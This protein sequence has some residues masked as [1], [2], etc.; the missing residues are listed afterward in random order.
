MYHMKA[1]SRATDM[2]FTD[3]E[4]WSLKS[5][6]AFDTF[7]E[8][9]SVKHNVSSEKNNE[10]GGVRRYRTF[11]VCF[12]ESEKGHVLYMNFN[13]TV[14]GCVCFSLDDEHTSK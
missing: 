1:I 3:P 11:F 6:S 10:K 9:L 14:D 12:E 4:K 8:L 5:A 7:I 13:A 2:Q